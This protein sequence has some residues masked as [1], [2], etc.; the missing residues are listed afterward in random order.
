[1]TSS[2][3]GSDGRVQGSLSSGGGVGIRALIA[4]CTFSIFWSLA[5]SSSTYIFK[6][7][8]TSVNFYSD[9]HTTYDVPHAPER[10]HLFRPLVSSLRHRAVWQ[11]CPAILVYLIRA[12]PE[13]GLP[14]AEDYPDK[15]AS[16][17]ADG[18]RGP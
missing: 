1:M 15:L 6:C 3:V 17:V 8:R 12:Q 11:E 2:L 5:K 7:L 14:L 9:G 16:L 10:V 13:L 18:N 4:T